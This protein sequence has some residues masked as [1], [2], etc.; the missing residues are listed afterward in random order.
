[1]AEELQLGRGLSALLGESGGAGHASSHPLRMVALD[2]LQPHARQP[3]E[4]IDAE[5]LAE[6]TESIRLH[7]VL[8]P[9][10][11]R[12]LGGDRYELVAGER[13]WRAAGLAGLTEIPVLIRDFPDHEALEAAILENVQRE[14]L[15]PMEIARGFDRLVQEFGYSHGGIA[16]RLGCSRMHISNAV[17]LLK[18]PGTIQEM[19]SAGA[20]S[21]GHARALLGFED[22]SAE[23]L[24]GVAAEVVREQMSVRETERLVRQRRSGT[25]PVSRETRP[26]GR[27]RDPAIQ[28]LEARLASQLQTR[29]GITHQQG[30]GHIQLEYASLE[31]LEQLVERLLHP[32]D[33]DVVRKP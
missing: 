3:R 1:M 33:G 20:L 28:A 7:G 15:N 26:G 30:R 32:L 13:R 19:V 6:L 27:R 22:A 9:V 10:L 21:Q 2:H 14:D 18:L 11:A 5:A 29:V 12:P 4:E 17:R 25:K 16:R 31:E 23:W 8:Q 24:T